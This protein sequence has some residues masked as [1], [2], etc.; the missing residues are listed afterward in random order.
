MEVLPLDSAASAWFAL[1]LAA[2]LLLAVGPRLVRVVDRIADRSGLGEALTGAILLGATTSLPGIVVTGMAAHHGRADLSV[3]NCLGGIGAQTAF[4]ILADLR[5][6]RANLEHAAAS[7]PNLVQAIVLVAMLAG[8]LLAA[9]GPELAIASIHPVSIGL[10]AFYAIGLLFARQTHQEPMWRPTITIETRVDRPAERASLTSWPRLLGAFLP[11]TI[12]VAGSGWIT[13]LAG[14]HLI[15]RT[16][17]SGSLV[18]GFVTSIVTSLPELVTV[19]AAV[20]MGALTLAIADI[21]GGNTFDVL[22][23][24]IGD[25]FYRQGSIYHGLSRE[26]HFLTALAIVLTSLMALGLVLRNRKG[27]GFEGIAILAVYFAGLVAMS[28]GFVE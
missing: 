2:S 7:L 27:I 8:V 13:T 17:L 9:T 10:P 1:I 25:L 6:R 26:T 24:T 19:L 28:F 11:M 23:V 3:S 18:G 14:Q 20:R 15:D 5:Y 16:G 22:F 21:V 12:L 4:L